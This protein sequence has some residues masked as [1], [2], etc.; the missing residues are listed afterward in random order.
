VVE[1]EEYKNF[2]LHFTKWGTYSSMSKDGRQS[3]KVSAIPA[4]GIKSFS[5]LLSFISVATNKV[6]D[7][8]NKQLVGEVVKAQNTGDDHADDKGADDKGG[9]K[10]QNNDNQE[11]SNEN[12]KNVQG[13]DKTWFYQAPVMPYV[14]YKRQNLYLVRILYFAFDPTVLTLVC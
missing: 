9:N 13:N 2:S 5:E 7:D 10:G 3:F 6:F 11:D 4:S 8:E 14:P 1:G 12:K